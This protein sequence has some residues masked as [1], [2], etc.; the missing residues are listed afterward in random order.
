MNPPSTAT[1]AYVAAV[2]AIC[3]VVAGIFAE[4][5]IGQG[6]AIIGAGLAAYLGVFKTK[7]TETL[8]T[9]PGT[10]P[11]I[12]DVVSKTGAVVGTVV[13]DTGAATGGLIAGTTGAVGQALDATLGQV[14]PGG[15]HR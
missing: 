1:K 12:K 6:A 2:I 10:E 13:A 8:E 15:R 4:S 7:N 3:S 11:L 14:L 5:A 9:G